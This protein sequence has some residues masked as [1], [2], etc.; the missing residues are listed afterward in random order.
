MNKIH[1]ITA[2]LFTAALLAVPFI[3]PDHATLAAPLKMEQADKT[4]QQ[5]SPKK[6]AWDRSSLSFIG[7]NPTDTGISATIKNG[8]DSLA[9]QGEVTYELFWSEQGNPKDGKIVATGVV[10][11]LTPG[12]TQVLT[13]SSDDLPAGNYMF[14]A[15][16]RPDHPGKGE[17]WSE[18]ITL[19][20]EIKLDNNVEPKRPFDQFFNSSLNGGTATFTIP[21]GVEPVEISFTSYTYPDGIVPQDLSNPYELQTVY[22]NVTNVYGPGTYSIEVD[23]PNGYFQTDLYLGPV[24]EKL[25]ETGHPIDKIIDADSGFNP[26]I[27]VILNN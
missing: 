14:K 3:Q 16:Q 6:S 23:L 24:I 5:V 11:A 20:E 25:T 13:Y 18:S 21:E 19:K 9:M 26:I 27:D 2:G 7:A 1:K 12:E 8:Q 17:L 10:N 22:D 4:K 15:Y